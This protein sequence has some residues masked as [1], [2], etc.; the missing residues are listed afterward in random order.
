MN[1]YSEVARTCLDFVAAPVSILDGA[2]AT[3]PVETSTAPCHA[4]PG[5]LS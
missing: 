4:S 5:N 1:P 2:K 3:P